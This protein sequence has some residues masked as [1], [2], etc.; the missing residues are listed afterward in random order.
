M[1]TPITVYHD[2]TIKLSIPALRQALQA[3]GWRL[4]RLCSEHPQKPS[5]SD[6]QEALAKTKAGRALA[7]ENEAKR[8][9]RGKGGKATAPEIKVTGWDPDRLKVIKAH[10]KPK[11]DL[12]GW[13][14]DAC[15]KQL[16]RDLNE[17]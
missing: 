1:T 9:R 5:W 4:A 2:F 10:V 13:V 11:G 15:E 12:S 16:K 6:V 17:G 14:R 8:P 7:A 3:N